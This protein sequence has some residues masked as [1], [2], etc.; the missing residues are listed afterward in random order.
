MT[1]QLKK[2]FCSIVIVAIVAIPLF[3][4]AET[5][6]EL[7]QQIQEKQALILQ[8]EKQIADYNAQIKSNKAQE[9]TLAKQ[10]S[11]LKNQIKQLEAEVKL[12]QTKISAATL[13]I[14]E[15]SNN[16]NAEN[17][18]IEKQKYN[19]SET[20]RTIYEYDQ[21]S[22]LHLVLVNDTFSQFLNRST[23]HPRF[24]RRHPRQNLIISKI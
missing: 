5:Q 16:I 1:K 4:S 12:T 7:E 13:K 19:L 21:V 2:I 10:I 14:E 24:A 20:L 9:G 15:L 23:S 11:K 22:P 6:Q 18:E 8:L 17:V 3:S